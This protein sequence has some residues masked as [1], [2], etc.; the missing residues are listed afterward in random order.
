MLWGR[1]TNA[2]DEKQDTLASLE[3]G[4]TAV[5]RAIADTPFADRL[6]TLGFT[7]HTAVTCVAVSPLGD[8]RAYRIKETVIA[9]R[10]RDAAMVLLEDP[11]TGNGAAAEGGMG[12][13]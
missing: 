7:P 8:P 12:E 9:L 6:Y 1:N 3:G 13:I 10:Y 4:R 5:I 2:T 11:E